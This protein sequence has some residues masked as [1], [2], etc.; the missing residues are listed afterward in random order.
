MTFAQRV[1]RRLRRQLQT[2]DIYA[3]TE[4]LNVAYETIPLAER[5]KG[6]TGVL[7]DKPY[8]VVNSNLP[9]PWQKA[10]AFHEL[11]HVLLHDAAGHFF[12][13]E[14][15]LFPIGKFERQANEFAAEYLIP[16]AMCQGD[17][18]ILAE[19]L[20]VPVELFK[21][22]RPPRGGFCCI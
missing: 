5:I 19:E 6:F 17:I 20:Q 11:G 9:K 3:V 14:H 4:H 21:F 15:T 1:A 16:D 13:E 7:R 22:K 10:V 18:R 12:I 8:I 2:T